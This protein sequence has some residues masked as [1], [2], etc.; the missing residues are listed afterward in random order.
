MRSEEVED[1]RL[2]EVIS[3]M[4]E[5]I[6][7]PN[8]STQLIPQDASV[9]KIIDDAVQLNNDL[10][11]VI[12]ERIAFWTREKSAMAQ[13]GEWLMKASRKTA[14]DL[15]QKIEKDYRL[16]KAVSDAVDEHKREDAHVGTP[17]GKEPQS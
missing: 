4:E 7:K 9:Q 11:A 2:E 16:A 10:A 12:E 17:D 3:H 1:E 13:F 14:S 8:G 5:D 15:N 6:F